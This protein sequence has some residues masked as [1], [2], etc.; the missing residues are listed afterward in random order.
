M[1]H[2]FCKAPSKNWAKKKIARKRILLFICLYSRSSE[3][4]AAAIHVWANVS[5]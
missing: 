4:V 1:S 2:L 5:M 3:M